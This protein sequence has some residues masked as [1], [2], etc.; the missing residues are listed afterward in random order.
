MTR[1]LC[2]RTALCR[3]V[4]GVAGAVTAGAMTVAGTGIALADYGPAAQ[5]QVEIAANFPPN[6]SGPGTGGGIWLWVE[7]DGTSPTSGGS[8]QLHG[9]DCLHHALGSTGASPDSASVT[10]TES[11]G[12]ITIIGFD[13]STI[14][15]PGTTGHEELALSNVFP[16]LGPVP[17]K[18]EVTVA[19]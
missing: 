14:V 7:L 3:A 5:H 11:N 9:S 10:W 15:V 4:L 13:L 12:L 16:D 2:K 1:V 8:G 6:F 19:P 18:A 17:G